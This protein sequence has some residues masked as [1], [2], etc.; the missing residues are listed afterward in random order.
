MASAH[1]SFREPS[2]TLTLASLLHRT[3]LAN[4]DVQPVGLVIHRL[5]AVG[6]E[7][8]VFLGEVGLREGL[9][10]HPVSRKGDKGRQRNSRS[11]RA[12]RQSSCPRAC[13]SS[14]LRRCW[15]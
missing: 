4:M 5:H 12:S 15:T 11:H 10:K 8:A 14:R 2:S 9:F 6:P 7:D 1:A 3:I 13:S